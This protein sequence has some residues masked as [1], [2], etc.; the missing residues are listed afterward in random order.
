[1]NPMRLEVVGVEGP[2]NFFSWSVSGAGQPPTVKMIVTNGVV[3]PQFDSASVRVGSHEHN[4]WGFST[5]G[6]YRVTFRAHGRFLGESTDTRGRDVAWAFQL[7]PLRPWEQWVST[8]WPPATAGIVNGPGADPDGDGIV[9]LLE[10][11]FGNDPNVALYTNAPVAALVNHEGT[12]YGALRYT[13]A[14]HATDV[15]FAVRASSSTLAGFTET[16]TQ[17]SSVVTNGTLEIV[18]VRDAI[19]LAQATHRLYQLHVQLHYP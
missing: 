9:N 16:L 5:N 11:A 12:N 13:R 7:L 6:L 8:N 2:G 19:P 15:T 1:M 4:N 14:I 3:A 18:T 17:V 10:Y